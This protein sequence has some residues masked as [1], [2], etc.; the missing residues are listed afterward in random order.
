MHFACRFL[1]LGALKLQPSRSLQAFILWFIFLLLLPLLH[2]SSPESFV[3]KAL[4]QLCTPGMAGAES[5]LEEV[6]RDMGCARS[7]GRGHGCHGMFTF[8]HCRAIGKHMEK[9]LPAQVWESPLG[10]TYSLC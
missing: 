4:H 3:L 2:V 6:E 8:H 1:L 7:R 10:R 9:H 5:E